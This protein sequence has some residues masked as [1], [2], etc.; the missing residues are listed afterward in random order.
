MR[1]NVQDTSIDAYK[2]MPA[3]TLARSCDR[4]HEC[5]AQGMRDG[6]AD[7]SLQEIKA[8]YY[9]KWGSRIDLS[10]VSGRVNELVAAARLQ[11]L[12]S[13]RACS[14]TGRQIHPVCIPKV[15]RSLFS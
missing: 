10:S 1:T 9:A 5:V 11:R 14:V 6:H 8:A 13:T 3:R 15:Q 12:E 4:V 2:R 7:M